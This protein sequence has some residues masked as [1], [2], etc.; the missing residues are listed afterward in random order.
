VR[1][2]NRRFLSAL[3]D[4]AGIAEEH[5]S[6]FFVGLDKLD[7][8]GWEGVRAEL[9]NKG[10]PTG[11]VDAALGRIEKMQRL[12]AHLV[13]DAVA[14]EVP[15]L[16]DAVLADLA[17]TIDCL[18]AL[19]HRNGVRWEFDP[20]L[21][22]GM[23]Y[24]T[25]QIFEVAHPRSTSS[26]AGG[27][28]Y[29]KLIGRSLGRDVPACGFSIGFERIVELLDAAPRLGALAV[30]IDRDVVLRD[31]LALAAEHRSGGRPVSVVRRG[32]KLGTQLGRLADSGVTSFAYLRDGWKLGDPVEER[33]LGT[34]AT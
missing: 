23:G 20:T 12:P 17:A 3:T 29:D 26:I 25:G 5:R 28:R 7:K 32:G 15:A 21:V 11:S 34:T 33:T 13:T 2:S 22:R 4:S 31:A 6:A 18:K 27:G 9:A 16:A 1:L 8:L 10:L 19:A 14:D 30:L 24:Y